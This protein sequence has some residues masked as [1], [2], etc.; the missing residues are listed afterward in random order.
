MKTH[1]ALVAVFLMGSVGTLWIGQEISLAED[2][3]APAASKSV[4][5]PTNRGNLAYVGNGAKPAIA[6][7]E[8]DNPKH[9][10]SGLND[11][12]YG[13]DHS[14]IPATPNPWFQIELAKTAEGRP[15]QL[16]PRPAGRVRRPPA[17]I[18]EDRAFGRRPTPGK[19]STRT[20]T[21]SPIPGYEPT[22]TLE[23]DIAP[24]QA[25]FVKVVRRAGRLLHRRV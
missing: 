13:N 2:P 22:A 15:L 21:S 23:I 24:S 4:E 1:C 11:G 10:A 17:E 14:W 18:A 19:Q 20:R 6:S 9:K 7:S 12:K 25:R 8:L 16:G 3:A 5:Q